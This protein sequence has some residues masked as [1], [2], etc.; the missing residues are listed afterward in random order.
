[1]DVILDLLWFGFIF[2]VLGLTPLV[3]WLA[4]SWLATDRRRSTPRSDAS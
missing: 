2:T 3:T 4:I 1:M